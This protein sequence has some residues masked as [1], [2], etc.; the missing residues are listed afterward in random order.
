M[1]SKFV[2]DRAMARVSRAVSGLLAVAMLAT[3]AGALAA[4][5]GGTGSGGDGTGTGGTVEIKWAVKDSWAANRDGVLQ[6]L[7]EMGYPENSGY[8]H[9]RNIA[10]IDSSI[11]AAADECRATYT[12]TD[13]PDC[14]LVAVGIAGESGSHQWNHTSSWGVLST[15]INAWNAETAGKT[16]YHNGTPWTTNMTWTDKK[17]PRS[18]N[19]LAKDVTESNLDAAI[20]VIVLAKNQP[21]PA[22]YELSVTTNHAQR[23]D[24]KV[25]DTGPVGDV[26]HADAHGSDIRENLTATAIVHYEGQKDGYVAAKSVSRQVTI[27]NQGDTRLA[28]L[29]TPADFGMSHWQEGR[30]WIDLQVPKQGRMKAA[31]DTADRDPAESWDVSSVPP[32]PPVKSV[33]EGVSADSMT[34]RTSITYGTGKGGYEMSFRDVIDPNGVQYDIA[35]YKLVDKSDNDRDVSGEFTIDWDRTTNT[36]SAVRTADKGEMPLDHDYEFSFD[37]TVHVP[38]DWQKVRDHAT[39]TW[40]HEPEAD[41]GSK[42]FDTWRPNPDKSWITSTGGKWQAVIDPQETNRTGADGHTFLDGDL[43]GSVVNGTIGKDLIQA[44]DKLALTD[45][46]TAADYIWDAD[47]RNIR[48]YEADAGTDRAS[49]VSDIV[50]TGKDVTDQFTISVDGTKATATAKAGYLKGLKG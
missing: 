46:W 22:E 15:W 39:G 23:T 49:S 21:V 7:N 13:D 40:N 25:G 14:R 12:G 42:E 41:G 9:D 10:T 26:V 47:T 8:Q 45:D 16:Y 19:T 33:A 37:V 11:A 5:G 35:N 29:A 1:G 6:A 3:P 30:Y 4:D 48:V 17:G 27:A 28:N 34:N 24:M 44:P 31:V 2:R 18:V 32:S 20:R 38:S 43:L 50:N 36:V